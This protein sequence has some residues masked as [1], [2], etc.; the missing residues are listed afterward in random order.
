MICHSNDPAAFSAIR[1]RF[2]SRFGIGDLGKGAYDFIDW[3]AAAKQQL[4]QVLPLG[5]TG[6]GDSPYQCFSAFAGNPLL[7]SP[8]GLAYSGLLPHH[9]LYDMPYF[10]ARTASISA[11]SLPSSKSLLRKAYEHFKENATDAQHAGFDWFREQSA[12]WL[13]DF[14]LFMAVKGHYGGGSWH[15]WPRDIRLREPSA[16]A[17]MRPGVGGRG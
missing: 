14:T 13:P 16:L 3:L 17:R 1:P 10:P 6:Y 2:P 11:R 7:I 4:W 5:P 9:A 15:D 12:S 8:E